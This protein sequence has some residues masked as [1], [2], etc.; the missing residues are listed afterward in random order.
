[1]LCCDLCTNT[2][3]HSTDQQR[4]R[5]QNSGH[6]LGPTEPNFNSDDFL[7]LYH[8]FHRHGC[9]PSLGTCNF[10]RMILICIQFLWQVYADQAFSIVRRKWVA[11]PSWIYPLI[12]DSGMLLG[13]RVTFVQSCSSMWIHIFAGRLTDVV[14]EVLLPTS[15][16][17]S[18]G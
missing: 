2:F 11:H 16:D 10:L 15:P 4:L 5:T 6:T 7:D 8:C 12:I 14:L 3:E 18:F 9:W 13:F 17:V 1:M